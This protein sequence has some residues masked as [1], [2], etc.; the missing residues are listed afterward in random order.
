MS[1][2]ESLGKKSQ[3]HYGQLV[4]WLVVGLAAFLTTQTHGGLVGSR[5]A[6]IVSP[7]SLLPDKMVFSESVLVFLKY[8]FFVFSLLWLAQRLLPLSSW[9]AATSFTLIVALYQEQ[10]PYV[11]HMFHMTNMVLW[12]YALWYHFY[13]D[14]IRRS[15]SASRFW[16]SHLFPRW[17]YSLTLAYIA[18]FY[19]FAGI[20]KCID[21][22][23][24]WPNGVSMQLWV[25]LWGK[26]D[27][28]LVELVLSNRALAKSLQWGALVLETGALLMLPFPRLRPVFGFGLVGFHIGQQ[29]IFGWA[30]HG[31]MVLVA[32]TC[33]PVFAWVEQRV[34]WA[35][36][37][38]A[39]CS[40]SA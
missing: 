13:A 12:I 10:R 7:L 32:V 6:Q 28:H 30:F 2:L 4:L 24:D 39:G 40:Q 11:D 9:V 22:G 14:A 17:V 37:W 38:R 8:V 26:K 5:G 36:R 19:T 25:L 1:A 23:L 33:L 31:N 15:L 3:P 20:S 21:G 27:S 34:T 16:K 35:A 29:L 18:L